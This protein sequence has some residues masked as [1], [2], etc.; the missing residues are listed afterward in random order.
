MSAIVSKG[1]QAKENANKKDR[2]NLKDVL[3]K[4]KEGQS[5]KVRVLSAEDYVEY[6]SAGDF[7]IGIYTQAITPDSPLLVAHAKGGEKFKN[8][9]KKN[10]FCFVFASLE[11]GGLVA[12]Q[13]SKNQAQTIISNIE[14]YKESLGTFAFNIKRTGSDTST[15]YSLNP[16]IQMKPEEKA[17]FDKF[18]DVV[19]TDEFYEQV[20]EP[21]DDVFLAKLLKEAGFD[22]DTHL[23]HII[24]PEDEGTEPDTSA[25]EIGDQGSDED[26]LDQI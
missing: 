21:K 7:N 23:P 26:L 16:I 9:Y 8:L 3:V 4:L 17:T 14:D 5:H 10:R 18:N 2:I 22:T 24:I 15:V 19:V 20:L 25:E 1:Q 6:M 11:T 12:L 13:V